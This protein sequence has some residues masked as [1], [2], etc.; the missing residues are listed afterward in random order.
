I[1]LNFWATWCPP[2]RQEMPAMETLN[3]SMTGRPFQMI[4]I[5]TNDDPTRARNFVDQL[6][7]TFPVLI[8]PSSE[9]AAHYGIT[10]VPETFII[11]RNGILRE[12]YIGPRPWESDS[13]RQM[14]ENY[15]K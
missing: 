12:K 7:G 14:I 10:G 6:G 4:T 11:D 1:F 9:T 5:L 13:A 2:C 3:K 8:D 15:L